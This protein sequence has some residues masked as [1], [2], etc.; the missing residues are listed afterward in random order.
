MTIGARIARHGRHLVCRLAQ[1]AVRRALVAAILRRIARVRGLPV[2]VAGPEQ[3]MRTA[4]AEG[5]APRSAAG[6]RA[7]RIRL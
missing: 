5:H 3:I 6:T 4:G 1:V 7:A 2:A